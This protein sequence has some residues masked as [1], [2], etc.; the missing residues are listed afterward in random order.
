MSES[1]H[2]RSLVKALGGDIAS[3]TR[4]KMP[5]IV[6]FDLQDGISGEPPPAIG[7]NRPDAFARDISTGRTIVG[8][9]KTTDDIDNQH[10]RDQLSSYLQYLQ[11]Q[12]EGELWM[13]VPW[14]SAGTAL[15]VSKLV[16]QQTNSQSIPICVV[17]YM[18]GATTVRRFWRE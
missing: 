6:Y 2:H 8:E 17:A 15:R 12:T 1:D 4:W 5:P 11:S 10:T 7:A 13:A 3:D 16:R 9:A 14:M 18:I